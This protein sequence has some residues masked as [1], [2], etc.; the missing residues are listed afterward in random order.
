MMRER[1]VVDG[2]GVAYKA[3]SVAR[4]VPLEASAGH[5]VLLDRIYV[6]LRQ[7]LRV[8]CRKSL[9]FGQFR[10]VCIRGVPDI[11]Q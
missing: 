8:R 4:P 10:Q 2:F 6:T 5:P 7:H 1:C 11:Q 9:G 3:E